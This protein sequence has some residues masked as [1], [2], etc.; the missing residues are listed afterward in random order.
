MRPI[1]VTMPLKGVQEEFFWVDSVHSGET[2]G[3]ILIDKHGS[4]KSVM[5]HDVK[6][7]MKNF[8]AN[9]GFFTET[10][11]GEIGRTY[12]IKVGDK[13]RVLKDEANCTSEKA[14]AILTV[15]ELH[16]EYGVGCFS[17]TA[18]DSTQSPGWG[19]DSDSLAAGDIEVVE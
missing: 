16:P 5:H 18:S 13:I 9:A 6:V 1:K 4:V 8:N 17:T 3:L 7:D 15:V 2:T 12:N 11:E 19:F 10:P 14:G